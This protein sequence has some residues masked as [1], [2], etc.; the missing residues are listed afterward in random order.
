MS[1]NGNAGWPEWSRFILKELERLN[2]GQTAIRDEIYGM[3][4]DIK[5]MPAI[6]ESVGELKEW[7]REIS[8]IYSPT[9]LSTSK[10][11]LEEMKTF[12]TRAVTVWVVVQI[13]FAV[14]LAILGIYK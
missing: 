11:E 4:A 8:E 14:T 10:A 5:K 1:E 9:Q 12:K 3:R 6:E 2:E 13:I 7:K